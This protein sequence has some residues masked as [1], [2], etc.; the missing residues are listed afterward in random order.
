MEILTWVIVLAVLGCVSAAGYWYI[1]TQT[2]EGETG[3]LF[4]Q[5]QERRLSISEQATIDGRRKLVLIRRDG[6][7]HLIMTGGPVDVVIETGINDNAAGTR[8][9]AALSST[10]ASERLGDGNGLTRQPRTFARQAQEPT[11]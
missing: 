8:R 2:G 6:V 9:S 7:E 1:T 10:T 4:G 3:K 11:A 5:R